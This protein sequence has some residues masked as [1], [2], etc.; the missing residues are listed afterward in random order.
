MHTPGQWNTAFDDNSNPYGCVYTEKTNIALLVHKDDAALIAAAPELLEILKA[1]I[2]N[3]SDC[4]IPDNDGP[5]EL[6]NWSERAT[7]LIAKAE[8]RTK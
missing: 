7:Q 3:R 8:G 5:S 1:V 2:K 6:Y 4:F